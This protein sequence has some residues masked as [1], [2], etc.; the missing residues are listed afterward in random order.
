MKD[1]FVI[2]P[3]TARSVTMTIRIDSEINEKLEELALKSNRSR[4]ELINMSLRYAFE[5]L[6]FIQDK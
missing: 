1:K 5:N 4:N 3:K 6:E 2:K